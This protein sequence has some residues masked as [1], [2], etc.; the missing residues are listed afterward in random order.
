[1][2]FDTRASVFP[3]GK[4][5]WHGMETGVTTMVA[6]ND[7]EGLMAFYIRGHGFLAGRGDRDYAPAQYAVCKFRTIIKDADKE[8]IEVVFFGN[9][10]EWN[11]RKQR[12]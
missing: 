3:D 4:V 2:T 9:I 12:T 7:K 6:R 10:L 1:M 11:A 8:Q 5:T